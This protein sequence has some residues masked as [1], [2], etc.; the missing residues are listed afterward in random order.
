MNNQRKIHV[1]V[2]VFISVLV[3]LACNVSV[4]APPPQ[5]S[6]PSTQISINDALTLAAQTIQ[7]Q[8]TITSTPVTSSSTPTVT[9]NTDTNCRA[10]PSSDY[11]L[12]MLFEVGMTA[13]VV[14]KYT[15][16]N[17]WIIQIPNGGGA[18]CWLWGKYATVLGDASG[19]L[20]AL[21]PPTPPAPTPPPTASLS[22]PAAPKGVDIA[23]ACNPAQLGRGGVV[24]TYDQQITLTWEDQADNEAGYYIYKNGTLIAALGNNSTVFTDAF[25]VLAGANNEYT[26]GVQA[27][28]GAGTSATKEAQVHSCP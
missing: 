7:A 25:S 12:I 5:V 27:F 19:L 9:V 23:S 18:T 6:T 11:D 2:S 8:S 24:I 13:D 28:N 20:E 21:P 10:G 15:P 16:A 22:A 3:A 17:Y 1:G 14:G 26:Y 4:S